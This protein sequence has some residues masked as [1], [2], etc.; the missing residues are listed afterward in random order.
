MGLFLTRVPLCLSIDNTLWAL[1][2]CLYRYFKFCYFFQI[3]VILVSCCNTT[4]HIFLH[5]CVNCRIKAFKHWKYYACPYNTWHFYLQ[6]LSDNRIISTILLVVS[7]FSW[8]FLMLMKLD[9]IHLY[10]FYQYLHYPTFV[11][12]Y[13]VSY[14]SVAQMK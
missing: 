14:F 9:P 3:L 10:F 8:C 12:N 1:W 13:C 11:L 7:H 5:I 4:I 6:Y 2:Y